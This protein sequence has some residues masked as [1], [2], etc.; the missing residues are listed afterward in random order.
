MSPERAEAVVKVLMG[1]AMFN[2]WGVRTLARGEVAYNPIDYQV[3]AVWPH[4]NSLIAAGLKR[5]GY[6]RDASRIFSALFDAASRF[7][8]FRLPEVFSGIAR[9]EYPSPVRYP[10]ACSSQAWSAGTLPYLLETAP[11]LEANALKSEFRI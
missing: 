9:D 3:G 4:D 8:Q 10:V 6:G 11:G 1:E 2:G 7:E 5:H